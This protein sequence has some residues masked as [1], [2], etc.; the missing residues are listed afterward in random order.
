MPFTFSHPAIVLPLT[1]AR[2]GLS[3]TALIIGSI[4]PD[5]EYFIRM[6]NQSK[7]SHTLMGLIWFDLPLALL[8]CFVYHQIVRNSLFDNL[9]VFL[10]ERVI[11]YKRFNWPKYFAKNWI[12][13]CICILI[14][15]LTHLIWDDFTHETKFFIQGQPELSKI[16]KVGTINLAGY[17]FLQFISTVVGGMVVLLTIILLKRNSCDKRIDYKY[18]VF[19][20]LISLS[21]M[22]I[23]FISGL[24][25]HEHRVVIVCFLSSLTIALILTP[26]ILNK[27]QQTKSELSSLKGL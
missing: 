25:L 17:R 26:L 7:Y 14:G 23:K 22:G 2:L 27:K 20:V 18:W 16:M 6:R 24:N 1:R 12:I 4:I 10:K 15:A 5:F 9:P 13:V 19:I 21:V 8:V 3:A 11:E